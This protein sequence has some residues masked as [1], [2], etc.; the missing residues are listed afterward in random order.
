[1]RILVLGGTGVLGRHVATQ[2]LDRGQQVAVL[3]RRGGTRDPRATGFA[4]DRFGPLA[5]IPA[6]RRQPIAAAEVAVA[7]AELA[8]KPAAGRVP[9]IGGPR[10]EWMPALARA[11]RRHRRMR[12]AIMP[13][14]VPGATGR[15]MRGGGLLLDDSG[16]ARGPAFADWLATQST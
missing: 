7:V 3:S 4:G 1:M 15:G 10:V 12:V 2:L 11:V 14:Y 8:E 16:V 5:L 13:L 6:M 9:D